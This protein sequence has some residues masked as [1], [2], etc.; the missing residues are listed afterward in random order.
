MKGKL[1]GIGIGPGDPELL[2]LKAVRILKAVD[3]IAIPESRKEKGSIAMGIAAKHIKK[4]VETMT[5]TFPMVKEESVKKKFREENALRIKEKIDEG[6]TVA[7]LTLGDPM[8][9]STF[10]YILEYLKNSD[11][12]I[13]TVP[14][15]TSFC[16]I[17]SRLNVPITSR[18]ENLAIIPVDKNTDFESLLEKTDNL[19]F[20]KVSADNTRLADT[21]KKYEKDYDFMITTKCGTPEEKISYRLDDLYDDVT[22]LTTMIVKRKKKGEDK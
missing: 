20:M 19:V 22:Y 16:A 21:L 13:E 15:I 1:Y 18:N 12:D 9:Y 11:V 7:F 17:G 3:V 4:D 14:G 6:K 10:I 8:I 5:L 2:T